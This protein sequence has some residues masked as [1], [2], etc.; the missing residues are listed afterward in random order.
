MSFNESI[1]IHYVTKIPKGVY[2]FCNISTSRSSV[3]NHMNS[4]VMNISHWRLLSVGM[5]CHEVWQNISEEYAAS[6]F[7]IDKF[8]S[9]GGSARF[10]RN[11]G[12]IL[13]DY[14]A[15]HPGASD[16][17]SHFCENLKSHLITVIFFYWLHIHWILCSSPAKRQRND[18]CNQMLWL[19][20]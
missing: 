16:L 15:S 13:M 6:I 2:Y 4:S 7:R 20:S 19:K 5:W 8:Y 18:S 3:E 14:T 9:E 17:Y 10:L 1:A 11:V 12:N